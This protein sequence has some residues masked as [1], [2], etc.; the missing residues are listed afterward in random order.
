MSR[1]V[2]QGRALPDDAP[3]ASKARAVAVGTL[4]VGTLDILDAMIFF[5]LWRDIPPLRIWQSVAAGLLGRASFDGG[6]PT[7]VLGGLLHYFI[8]FCVVLVYMAASRR[9]DL[10]RRAPVPFG[11]LYGIAVFFAMSFVV[12][13]LSAAGHAAHHPLAWWLN[14]LIGHA[15]LIGLPAALAASRVPPGR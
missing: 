6:L 8:S 4:V 14:G 11:L 10:L 5:G 3:M 7:A 1:A 15:L 2:T 13:P 12:V 9:I